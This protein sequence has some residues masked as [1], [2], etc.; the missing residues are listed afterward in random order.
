MTE[1]VNGES[2]LFVH[3]VEERGYRLLYGAHADTPS[4]APEEHRATVSGR[5]DRSDELVALRLVVAK[6]QRRVI[7]DGYD[8]LLAAFSAHLHLLRHEI[9]LAAAQSREL[10]ETHPRGIKQLEDR[11]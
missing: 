6:R 3:L 11:E 10:G 2:G 7:A 8:A 9:E 5:A 4:G 1:R